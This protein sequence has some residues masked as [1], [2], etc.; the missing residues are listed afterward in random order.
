M[1]NISRRAAV[2]LS[3]FTI[4]KNVAQRHPWGYMYIITNN[5]NNI[6]VFKIC[7]ESH[8]TFY[9]RSVHFKDIRS[10]LMIA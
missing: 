5:R 2:T 8:I 10:L 1:N 7:K 3:S 9:N 4:H 6:S